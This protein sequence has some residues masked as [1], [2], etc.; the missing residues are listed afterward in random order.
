MTDS[1]DAD[2]SVLA[3]EAEQR[4]SIS[5]A[6]LARYARRVRRQR[7]IY[8]PIVG[9]VLLALVITFVVAYL[10]GEAH[11]TRS[12]TVAKAPASL[13]VQTPTP[14]QHELWHTSD[15]AAIGTPNY[16]GTVVVYGAHTVRG[17][18]ARTGEQTWSYYRSDR[19]VCSTAQLNG[20][21]VAVYELS[22]NC[23]EVTGLDAGT[24]VLQW[25][26]TLDFNGQPLF[27]QPA[28]QAD[29]NDSTL[30]IT[31]PTVIYAVGAGSGE[32]GGEN[33]FVYSHF[34]CEIHGAV[35]GSSGGLISQTCVRPRCGTGTSRQ[36]FCGTGPQLLIRPEY[37]PTG[38]ASA[39]NPNRIMWNQFG[40][41][42]VPLSAG[43]IVA[44]GDTANGYLD[45]FDPQSGKPAGSVALGVKS[46]GWRDVTSTALGD[47]GALVW[48]DGRLN[49][50]EYGSSA[51][52]WT[53]ASAGP[54]SISHGTATQVTSFGVRLLL[55]ATGTVR[56]S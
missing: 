16:A 52:N 27:G 12:I 43:T 6:A 10:H 44:A 46:G 45:L 23:D 40:K 29:E 54:P 4:A 28:F 41:S 22:G 34:G 2:T 33:H 30:L 32:T 55:A 50:V 47:D 38:D 56:E 51:V 25:T 36:K 24:G 14:D 42:Y 13:T 39:T 5:Q 8:Y 17:I 11:N 20:I 35:V 15:H 7:L 31:T 18:D 21:A 49:A 37:D 9:G 1:D 48:S 3:R 53:A 26:R 19:T